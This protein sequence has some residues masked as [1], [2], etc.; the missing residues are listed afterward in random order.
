MIHADTAP[1]MMVEDERITAYTV[2]SARLYLHGQIDLIAHQP[3]Y[4]EQRLSVFYRWRKLE[5]GIGYGWLRNYGAGLD[6]PASENRFIAR[7]RLTQPAA[8]GYHYVQLSAT[9][10]SFVDT[11]GNRIETPRFVFRYAQSYWAGRRPLEQRLQ[12]YQCY[13]EIGWKTGGPG[14]TAFDYARLWGMYEIPAGRTRLAIGM[15]VQQS[16]RGSGEPPLLSY[17]PQVQWTIG[18]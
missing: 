8:Y 12:R 3:S 18:S 5:A 15:R 7:V 9:V 11:A 1:A 13:E 10:K 14:G 17:G 6:A 2:L 16:R 4:D